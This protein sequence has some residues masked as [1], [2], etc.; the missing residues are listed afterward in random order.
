ML[1]VTRIDHISMA[2]RELEPQIELLERLF[3]F[4]YRSRFA[5]PGYVGAELEVP[6]RSG[7]GWEIL[8]PDGPTSYLHRF[9]D[10]ENGPGLHHLA[11]Q[12]SN[13]DDAVREMR[14]LGIEPW[15]YE[16]ASKE[17][18]T[19]SEVNPTSRQDDGTN[20]VAYIHPRAG[21]AGFL[22]QLYDGPPWHLPDPFDDERSDSLGI[23]AINGLAHAHHSRQDLGDWY[24]RLFGFR[25]IHR[26]GP[27]IAELS[28]SSRTLESPGGQLRI[29]VMQPVR[30]DSFLQRFLD[31]RGPAVHHISFEVRD[32]ERAV[33]VAERNRVRVFGQ[34]SGQSEGATWSEAFLAPE[35]TGGMLV[36]LFSWEPMR[37]PGAAADDAASS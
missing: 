29:E 17:R 8:A 12:V 34:R 16:P 31:R 11:M 21:G 2:V 28:F 13:M 20:A 22:F 25:T 32:V 6:G 14:S 35:D 30:E 26:S 33:A 3:G 23:T 24:E 36:Q 10:G 1:S 7:I 27:S 18:G 5:Q 15:G 19:P 4:R 37:T 9:L